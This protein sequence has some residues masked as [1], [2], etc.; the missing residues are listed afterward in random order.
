MAKAKPKKFIYLLL[1]D[2]SSGGQEQFPFTTQEKAGAAAA[3]VLDAWMEKG[4]RI[5]CDS[6]TA[7]SVHGLLE[8]GL[9][10]QAITAWNEGQNEHGDPDAKLQI[11]TMQLD[12]APN[13]I[14]RAQG[15]S[16]EH[17]YDPISPSSAPSFRIDED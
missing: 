15:D 7:V 16:V 3:Q 5:D 10:F 6:V 1:L 2:Y 12:P 9:I 13:E 11:I 8:Q 4:S 14:I 17:V